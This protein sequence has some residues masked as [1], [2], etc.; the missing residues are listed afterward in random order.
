[1]R[2]LRADNPSEA[3]A[4][5]GA[6]D[7]DEIVALLP[8]TAV[9]VGADD[10]LAAVLDYFGAELVLASGGSVSAIGVVSSLRSLLSSESVLGVVDEDQEV[11]TLARSSSEFV[12]IAGRLHSVRTGEP[13]VIALIDADLEV[14][15]E[16]PPGVSAPV[17]TTLAN[18][19]GGIAGAGPLRVVANEIVQTPMWTADF[20]AALVAAADQFDRWGSDDTDPVPG[21][22]LSLM[23]LSPRLFAALERDLAER[24]VPSLRTQWPHFAWCGLHDAFV[25][26]YCAASAAVSEL[27]LH[28]DV[29]QVSG[30]VRLNAGY[31]GG[32]LDFPRQG[33]DTVAAPVGTLT[34][35]PSLVTHPH[36]ALPVTSGVKYNLTLWLRLP[37]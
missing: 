12:E 30:S 2:V 22:E 18:Y 33:F 10:E 7:D 16:R 15:D 20:C 6:A 37:S 26:R 28:H 36:R 13:A 29:A 14:F 1:M 25:I 24:I 3:L 5:L 27:P 32:A 4:A 8:T 11:F 17:F 34:A 9:V 35:W 19:E 31:T 21:D 23:T